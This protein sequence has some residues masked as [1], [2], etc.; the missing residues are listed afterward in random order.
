MREAFQ[1]FRAWRVPSNCWT[2]Y[3]EPDIKFSSSS[4]AVFWWHLVFVFCR[5]LWMLL[6]IQ[7]G[8]FKKTLWYLFAMCRFAWWLS[9][10][11]VIF[12]RNLWIF[13]TGLASLWP[14]YHY[15]KFIFIY[16][17]VKWDIWFNVGSEEDPVSRM[18]AAQ[19]ALEA[20]AKEK[21]ILI[22]DL[23]PRGFGDFKDI[24][25]GSAT[26]FGGLAWGMGRQLLYLWIFIAMCLFDVYLLYRIVIVAPLVGDNWVLSSLWYTL[27]IWCSFW[28][29]R[30]QP[31][32]TQGS[33]LQRPTKWEVR[34]L[35]LDQ[36]FYLK[37]GMF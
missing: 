32:S 3:Q 6:L 18:E 7:Q 17:A 11:L 13:G 9:L 16:S 12:I 36:S 24:D 35:N 22:H 21:V 37:W 4:L 26:S 8:D 28:G 31:L 19:A 15:K 10:L 2:H 30:N 20:K 29:R 23:Q 14:S 27:V 5:T 34:Y 1:G 25:F 33:L